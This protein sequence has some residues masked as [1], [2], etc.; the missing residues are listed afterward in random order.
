MN[1]GLLKGKI[2]LLFHY[3]WVTVSKRT[4]TTTHCY[5]GNCVVFFMT[6]FLSIFLSIIFVI[7]EG[8]LLLD[9]YCTSLIPKKFVHCVKCRLNKMVLYSVPESISNNE[10]EPED[11]MC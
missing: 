6:Y 2:V 4:N 1:Y 3:F 7:V 9:I 5:F 8:L 10:P 11:V